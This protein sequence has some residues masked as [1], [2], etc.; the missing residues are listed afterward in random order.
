MNSFQIETN[1]ANIRYDFSVQFSAFQVESGQLLSE[2]IN[3][4]KAQAYLERRLSPHESLCR[5][6]RR[7]LFE[8]CAKVVQAEAFLT[9]ELH[10]SDFKKETINNFF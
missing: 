6:S 8:A 1:M 9:A 7:V 4:E 2:A 5:N 3:Y 10:N